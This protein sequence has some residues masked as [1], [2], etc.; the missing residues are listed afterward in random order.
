MKLNLGYCARRDMGVQA[1]TEEND[2]M[3]LFHFQFAIAMAATLAIH[4]FTMAAAS[5]LNCSNPTTDVEKR[6][7]EISGSKE[8]VGPTEDEPPPTPTSS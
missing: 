6:A 8:P 7:C 3:R 5:A 2:P 1:C 4:F